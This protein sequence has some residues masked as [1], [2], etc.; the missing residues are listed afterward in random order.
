MQ[1]IIPNRLFYKWLKL[2]MLC[3][4]RGVIIMD[5][6]KAFDKLNHNLLL[7]KLKANGSNKNALTFIQTILQIDINEQKWEISLTNGKRYQQVYPKAPFLA[8]YFSTFS[9]TISFFLLKLLHYVTMQKTILR[10]LR[11]K[12]LMLWLA[13]LGMILQ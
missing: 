2:G 12:T 8:L 6:S 10:I 3:C 13:D 9:S 4:K 5:I 11:T 7:C 1:N